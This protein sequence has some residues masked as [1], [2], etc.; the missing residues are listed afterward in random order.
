MSGHEREIKDVPV[1]SVEQLKNLFSKTKGCQ[2]KDIFSTDKIGLFFTSYIQEPYPLK[3]IIVM[4]V[5]R[6]QNIDLLFYFV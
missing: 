1:D 2:L 4:V 3:V 5:P 6:K